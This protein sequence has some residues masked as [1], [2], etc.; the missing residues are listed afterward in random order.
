MTSGFGLDAFQFDPS[1]FPT[2]DLDAFEERHIVVAAGID[3]HDE[4]NPEAFQVFKFLKKKLG[5][6]FVIA[7]DSHASFENAVQKVRYQISIIK[8]KKEFKA[9][10][11]NPDLHVIYDGHARFGRGACFHPYSGLAPQEGDQWENGTSEDSGIF[12]LG[13]PF[14]PVDVEDFD[15]HQYSF[16]PVPGDTDPP[17]QSERHPEAKRSLSRILM[18]KEHRERVNVS[19]RNSDHLY[20]GFLSG[21]KKRFILNANWNESQSTPFDLGATDLKCKVF[22]HFGCS[23]RLHFREIVRDEKFKGWI[24]P[25]PPTEKFAYFTTNPSDNHCTPVWIHAVLTYG[26]KNNF[27]SWF[28]SLE[29]AKKKANRNLKKLGR[30]YEV[31]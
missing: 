13:Y 4:D 11:E 15:H 9:A 16:S 21:G 19:Q 24:R 30:F 10:L 26:K 28:D 12:R 29:D 2:L 31:F 1:G 8:T 25:T 3:A 17:P 18:P 14:L 7:D 22:C 27:Q 23:S 6:D 5:D 20:W